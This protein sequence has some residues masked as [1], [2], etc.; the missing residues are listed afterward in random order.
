MQD[1]AGPLRQ[2]RPHCGAVLPVALVHTI[3]EE[4]TPGGTPLGHQHPQIGMAVEGAARDQ[5]GDGALAA[6]RRL[7]VVDDGPAPAAVVDADSSPR[8]VR[9]SADVEADD[10]PGLGE[11]GPDRVPFLVVPIGTPGRWPDGEK[12]ACEPG[13]AGPFDLGDGVVDVHQWD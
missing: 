13:V 1:L 2:G 9:F 4:R 6:E 8:V 5:L 3:G 12:S 11:G 7:D 10:H